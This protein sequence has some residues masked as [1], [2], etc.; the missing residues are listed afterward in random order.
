MT[1][2]TEFLIN[3]LLTLAA[4]FGL[5]VAVIAVTR[6]GYCRCGECEDCKLRRDGDEETTMTALTVTSVAKLSFSAGNVFMPLTIWPRV[7]LFNYFKV[8]IPLNQKTRPRLSDQEWHLRIA[9]RKAERARAI[10]GRGGEYRW[11]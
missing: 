9:Q 6:S 4:Y 10:V 2:N 8:P 7:A 3:V 1:R 5:C 11:V